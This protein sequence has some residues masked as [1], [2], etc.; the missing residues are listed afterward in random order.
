MVELVEYRD[1]MSLRSFALITL[2]P[3]FIFGYVMAGPGNG[4]ESVWRGL[5][6]AVALTAIGAAVAF[7]SSP[8]WGWLTIAILAAVMMVGR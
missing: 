8:R 1:R 5:G 6:V 7:W 3:T 4:P 2:V